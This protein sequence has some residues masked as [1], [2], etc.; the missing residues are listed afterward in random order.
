[1]SQRGI[2]SQAVRATEDSDSPVSLRQR[3]AGEVLS[4]PRIRLLAL[5]LVR[6]CRAELLFTAFSTD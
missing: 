4:K 3:A 2:G 5:H 6:Y 1:M